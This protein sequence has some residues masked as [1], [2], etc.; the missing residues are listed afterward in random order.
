LHKKIPVSTPVTITVLKGFA[1]LKKI[2]TKWSANQKQQG[3]VK[4][5]H[6]K[7]INIIPTI[8]ALLNK[9]LY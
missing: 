4:V 7:Q 8:S 9:S 6:T 1:M 2:W 5:E 3:T